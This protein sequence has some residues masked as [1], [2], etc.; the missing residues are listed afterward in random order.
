MLRRFPTVLVG[1]LVIGLGLT[2]CSSD[3]NVTKFPAYYKYA[4]NI[5]DGHNNV[6]IAF[7][8]FNAGENNEESDKAVEKMKKQVIPLL[9]Q[10]ATDAAKVNLGDA[11]LLAQLHQELVDALTEKHAAYKKMVEGYEDGDVEKF[12][13]GR[14][15]ALRATEK[16]LEYERKLEDLRRQVETQ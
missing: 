14:R 2:A 9:Q 13:E 15:E 3:P 11:Q 10:L 1:L 5:L 7:R 16:L 6:G 4:R 12:N 8:K